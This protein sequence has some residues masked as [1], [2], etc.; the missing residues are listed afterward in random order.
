MKPFQDNHLLL[1][2]HACYIRLCTMASPYQGSL[3]A[4]GSASSLS[5]SICKLAEQTLKCKVI[6]SGSQ[7]MYARACQCHSCTGGLLK[8]WPSQSDIVLMHCRARRMTSRELLMSPSRLPPN[9]LENTNFHP[10]AIALPPHQDTA[11]STGAAPDQRRALVQSLKAAKGLPRSWRNV[12]G[13]EE[14]LACASSIMLASSSPSCFPASAISS[15]VKPYL[16][17][18]V[19]LPMT[20]H[21]QNLS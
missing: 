13:A 12:C 14:G 11:S 17:M 18:Q 5:K 15:L 20:G 2:V 10:S 1:A 7:Q 8:V 6:A 9:A 3:A 16:H 21:L 19:L 4:A